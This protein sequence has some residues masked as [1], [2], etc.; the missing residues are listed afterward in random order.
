ME[1]FINPVVWNADLIEKKLI[2]ITVWNKRAGPDVQTTGKL[3]N[4]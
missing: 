3:I 4:S 2:A 1:D